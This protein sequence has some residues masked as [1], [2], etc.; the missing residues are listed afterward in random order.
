MKASQALLSLRNKLAPHKELFL[1]LISEKSFKR[2]AT[3]RKLSK[4]QLKA[5]ILAIHLVSNGT[6]PISRKY[7]DILKHS[8]LASFAEKNFDHRKKFQNISVISNL[9]HI[10]PI[11]HI[12][13]YP[14]VNS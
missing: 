12:Y 3:I 6:I 13:L 10:T 7:F 14:L 9:S 8:R 11:I 2:K 4:P 5:L 1:K